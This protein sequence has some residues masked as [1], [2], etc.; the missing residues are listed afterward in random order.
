MVHVT[1]HHTTA[2]H[3]TPHHSTPRHSTPHHTTPRHTTPDHT[4]PLHTSPLH[5]TPHLTTLHHLTPYLTT[6]HHTTPLHPAPHHSTARRHQ[7]CTCRRRRL[8]HLGVRPDNVLLPR[9]FATCFS[10]D[11]GRLLRTRALNAVMGLFGRPP[12]PEPFEQVRSHPPIPCPR[13]P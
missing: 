7:P 2:D 13:H 12:A 11:P 1:A 5:S 6:P 8:A 4:T 9:P 10:Q 3:T